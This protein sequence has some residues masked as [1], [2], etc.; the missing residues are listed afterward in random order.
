MMLHMFFSRSNDGISLCSQ[1]AWEER[2]AECWAGPG[3]E[4]R[5]K[6]IQTNQWKLGMRTGNRNGSDTR[7]SGLFLL[8]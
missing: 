7:L 1:A 5:I 4:A 2:K 6:E 3:N 8:A